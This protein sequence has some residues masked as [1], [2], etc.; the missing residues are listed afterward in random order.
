MEMRVPFRD[1][2]VRSPIV[3]GGP[4]YPASIHDFLAGI[5]TVLTTVVSGFYEAS[6]DPKLWPEVLGKLRDA[7]HADAAAVVS[8]DFEQGRGQLDH[9]VSID[10]MFVTAY[11]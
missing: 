2:S 10:A 6:M 4:G 11:R 8:H 3:G 7:L 1:G 9:S 5:G